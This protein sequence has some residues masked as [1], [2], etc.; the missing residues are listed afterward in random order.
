MQNSSIDNVILGDPNRFGFRSGVYNL[1]KV[2][3]PA[4]KNR[5]N[6]SRN[7]NK[8]SLRHIKKIFYLNQ[9]DKNTEIKCTKWNSTFVNIR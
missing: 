8:C 4:T 9:N 7:L 2:T 5:E 1:V 3:M 6:I